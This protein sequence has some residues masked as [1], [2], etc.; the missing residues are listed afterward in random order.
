MIVQL[1]NLNYWFT[2]L[3]GLSPLPFLVKTKWVQF[4]PSLVGDMVSS[5]RTTQMLMFRLRLMFLTEVVPSQTVWKF[6]CCTSWPLD[7]LHQPNI[8][9]SHFLSNAIMHTC[10]H[11]NTIF[12]KILLSFLR[13]LRIV[14]IYGKNQ[15]TS[16][17]KMWLLGH[18]NSLLKAGQGRGDGSQLIK[19]NF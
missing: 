12:K 1:L 16:R 5:N 3:Q 18:N 11:G 9:G 10:N 7:G 17:Y 15:E 13:K 4:S 2:L 6:L 14:S 8:C 19:V